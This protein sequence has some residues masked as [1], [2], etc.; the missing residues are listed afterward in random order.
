MIQHYQKSYSSA[1]RVTRAITG[2]ISF[3]SPVAGVLR[4]L[5]IWGSSTIATSTWNL[6]INGVAQ[7]SGGGRP[8]TAGA[9][10]TGVEVT[11]LTIIVAKGDTIA[12]DLDSIGQGGISMPSFQVDIDDQL[13]LVAINTA[14]ITA[15]IAN[16]AT[17]NGTVILGKRF[18]LSRVLTSHNAR[19]RLYKTAAART[20]DAA[21][22]FGAN[23][24]YG[25]EHKM[26]CDLRL[27][28]TTGL[29]WDM[30]PDAFGG[31]GDV[32]IVNQVYY[33]IQNLSG[34]T[35]AITVTFTATVTEY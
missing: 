35:Q 10:T 8:T 11:G 34:G 21:R 28:A 13:T 14:K 17:E 30:S 27:N 7:F 12:L 22:A 25:T 6:S 19:I 15:A 9:S 26:I 31:N 1:E 33:A 2:L 18:Q 4:S 20:A 23:S 16:N 32:P 24:W 3:R 5:Q 29:D